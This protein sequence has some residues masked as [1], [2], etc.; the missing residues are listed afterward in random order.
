MANNIDYN[1]KTNKVHT[2]ILS[3]FKYSY[4]NLN[5]KDNYLPRFEYK[6]NNISSN[7]DLNFV[8]LVIPHTI[9]NKVNESDILFISVK[10]E[11]KM[12]FT[13]IKFYFSLES[14]I[15]KEILKRY[16]KYKNYSFDIFNPDN[17][18]F[19]PCFIQNNEN[20]PVD[21]PPSY[22]KDHIST[23]KIINIS[24]GDCK[25]QEINNNSEIVI[26]C[27]SF[28]EKGLY[29]LLDNYNFYIIIKWYL[30]H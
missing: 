11:E 5:E 12:N 10:S 9:K 30:F 17:Q 21:F 25:Y 23:Q 28:I 6:N 19:Q 2:G 4:Y 22:I 8:K 14:V 7:I 3:N 26:N 24:D 29:V 15:S 18:I 20:I 27:N 16:N 1:I 13:N